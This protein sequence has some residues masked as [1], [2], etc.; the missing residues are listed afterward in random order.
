MSQDNKGEEDKRNKKTLLF[1]DTDVNAAKEFAK[2]EEAIL[3]IIKDEK[4]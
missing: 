4:G 2:E 3:N 1:T